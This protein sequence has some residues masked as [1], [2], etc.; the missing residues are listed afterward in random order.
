MSQD[1]DLFTLQQAARTIGKSE[2]TLR[3]LISSGR[4]PADKSTGRYFIRPADLQACTHISFDVIAQLEELQARVTTIE[5]AVEDLQTKRK[6]RI[7]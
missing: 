4:L 3:R 2:K 5:Q 1:I 6:R 7:S